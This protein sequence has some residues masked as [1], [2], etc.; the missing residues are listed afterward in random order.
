MENALCPEKPVPCG[1]GTQ[2][3][4]PEP[5]PVSNRGSGW[6]IMPPGYP[7]GCFHGFPCLLLSAAYSGRRV[8]KYL[9]AVASLRDHGGAPLSRLFSIR[10]T[11]PVSGCRTG[12]L[13]KTF[14]VH[15]HP[16]AAGVSTGADTKRPETPA[17]C[18]HI[19]RK[20]KEETI[21]MKTMELS[22]QQ[23]TGVQGRRRSDSRAP[24]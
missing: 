11:Q 14:S 23:M 6:F 1:G 2:K 10:Q 3:K 7:K 18:R 17:G 9:L 20:D 21:M 12:P 16:R 8:C 5:C 13:K 24:R 19:E 15:C 22:E 4:R